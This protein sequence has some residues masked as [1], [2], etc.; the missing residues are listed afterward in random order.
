M[1]VISLNQIQNGADTKTIQNLGAQFGLKPHISKQVVTMYPGLTLQKLTEQLGAVF[2]KDTKDLN[3]KEI[4]AYEFQWKIKTNRIPRIMIA[5]DCNES[6][7][8]DSEIRLILEKKFY[9]IRDVFE[10]ENEQQVFVSRQPRQLQPNKVEHWVK[11][12]SGSRESS[13]NTNYLKRGKMTKYLTNYQPEL[14]DIGFSKSFWNAEMHRN[15]ISRHRIGD[16]FSGDFTRMKNIIMQHGQ[17][18]YSMPEME[19]D[20]LDQLYLAFENS[21]LLGAGNFDD[22]G[23]VLTNEVDGRAI[24]MGVGLIP[25][26]RKYCGQTRYF[27]LSDTILRSVISACVEKMANRTGNTIAVACNW[28]MY[29]QAQVVLDN[30]LKTRTNDAYFYDAKGGK[31]KVGAHY[32]AYE[33]AGNTIVFMHNDALTERYPDKGYGVFIDT[34][35]YGEEANVQMVTLKG[36]SLM[37]G[38]MLGMGGKTGGANVENLG[39]LVHGHRFELLGYRGIK[40]ANPYTSHILEENVGW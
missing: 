12:V 4:E 10:L 14:S 40:L 1:K 34:N 27:F 9:D 31:I 25:T 23:K 39:T 32:N 18:L 11:L 16:S 36:M 30:L 2:H 7:G 13:I 17:D 21:M 24:P 26:I 3:L 28:R 5:E 22:N 15:F 20:M 6:G 19:K 8:V 38:S 37:S 29:E 33:F 35:R